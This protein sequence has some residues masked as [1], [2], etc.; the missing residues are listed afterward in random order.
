MLRLAPAFMLTLALATLA[1]AQNGT[2]PQPQPERIRW[3]S[4]DPFCDQIFVNGASI[5][6]IKHK[7]LTIATDGQKSKDFFAIQTAVFNDT[8]QRILVDP[9]QSWFVVLKEKGKER[10]AN[11]SDNYAPLPPEKII[12][13]IENRAAWINAL[14][15]LGAALSTTSQTVNTYNTG[16]VSV[17]GTGTPVQGT[18]NGTGTATVTR[19]NYEAQRQAATA[20][21]ETAAKA[22]DEASVIDQTALR[23]NTVFPQ[24]TVAGYIFFP[25][26]KKA[27]ITLFI[28][29]IGETYYEFGF[30]Q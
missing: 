13:K 19:P 15:G 18:Y 8:G 29:K 27:E 10:K 14:R 20:N 28:L 3:K 25:M 7:G 2:T 22:Q 23:A 16:T 1:L 17:Y 21:A 11:L 9:A 24:T 30:G 4:N 26:I 12:A 6:I 5:R